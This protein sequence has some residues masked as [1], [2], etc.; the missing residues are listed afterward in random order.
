MSDPVGIVFDM[1]RSGGET[2]AQRDGVSGMDVL[3]VDCGGCVARG[4]ACEDCVVSVVLDISRRPLDL[5]LDE[6]S[7][8]QALADGGLVPPLR[9]IPGA[10]RGQAVQQ[11][12]DWP[13]S[14]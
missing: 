13:E 12:L 2:S 5:D 6:R 11:P 3:R 1:D 7:A 14:G 8:L 4:L 10:R 9:L